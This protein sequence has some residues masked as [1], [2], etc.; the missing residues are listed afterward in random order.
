MP[1]LGFESTTQRVLAIPELLQIIF[2]FGTRASNASNALVCRNWHEVALDYVWAEVDDMYYLLQILAPLHPRR[3]GTEFYTFRRTPTPEDWARFAPYAR[4]V[5]TLK[6]GTDRL[7]SGRAVCLGDSVFHDLARSRTTL[8]V[9]PNLRRLWWETEYIALRSQ[10]AVL[11]MH[12]KVKEF[13]F[14]FNT[15]D[16]MAL[17]TDV[18]GRM[19]SLLSL[20]CFVDYYGADHDP[21]LQY[22]LSHLHEL[23]E[24][25]L[26]KQSLGGQVLK[27][28]SLLPELRVVQFDNLGGIGCTPAPVIADTLEEGAFPILDDL[29]LD[30]TLEDMRNYLTGG[31]FLPR[32]RSLSVESVIPESSLAVQEFLTDVTRC[33]PSLE[34]IAVDVIVGIEEQD[35]CEPL[36][37]AHL[38]PILSLKQLIRL[39]LR[40]NLPLQISEVDLA[41]FGAALPAIEFLVLNPEP[42]LLSK[43]C[44]KIHSL[45]TIGQNFPNLFH[46]EIYLDAEDVEM[47]Q[48]PPPPPTNMR[49]FPHLR[50]LNVGVSPLGP[51]QVPV[52]LFLSYLLSDNEKVDIRSGSSWDPE[53]FDSSAE[54][55]TKL[56]ERCQRWEEVAKTLPLL[57]QLRKEERAHRR[58]IEKEVEDL[59]MRNEILMGNMSMRNA[60]P[61]PLTYDKGC[62]VC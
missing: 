28:L 8:E 4:R 3:G 52:A 32:I 29:C 43:P 30:S 45:P 34:T 23:Q 14:S 46:L 35:A 36:M 31:A 61:V 7:A 17:A 62:I 12:D 25:T 21:V 41:E 40:H 6:F 5:R 55:G 20:K 42:L 56:Q 57:L 48:L 49:V 19:P 18:V 9:F 39:E 15:E 22:L 58:D 13:G 59:R 53:L 10:H 11:F 27:S 1:Q 26:P 24:I 16:P 2:S 37:P 50:A 47:K 54:Y 60:K 51:D 44:L 38:H 33:Y